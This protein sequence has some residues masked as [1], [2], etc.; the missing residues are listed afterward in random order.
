MKRLSIITILIFMIFINYVP[1]MGQSRLT[2]HINRLKVDISEDGAL[3]YRTS[4][5]VIQATWPYESRYFSATRARKNYQESWGVWLAARNFVGV[6]DSIPHYFHVAC[7]NRSL[8]SE[9]IV[10]LSLNK[11]VRYPY[12]NVRISDG[13]TIHHEGF[14]SDQVVSSLP[15]DE[16]ITSVWTTALGLTVQLKTYA[17]A[18][19]KNL[20]YIIYD[21]KFTNTGNTDN[22]ALTR[23]L[24]APLQDVW[25]G[26]C[27]STDIKPRYGGRDQDDFFEYYGA[28]Y[29][30]WVNGDKTADSARIFYCWDGPEGDGTYEPDQ[31]TAEPRNPGYYA[32]GILHVDRQASDDLESGS[33]DGPS[34]PK[35]VRAVGTSSNEGSVQYQKM[36]ISLKDT[37]GY[38]GE[39]NYLM[40]CGPYTMPIN[41][42]VRIV[43]VQI[44]SGISRF[45]AKDLGLQLLAGEITQEEYEEVVATARDSVFAAFHAAKNAF[46]NRFKLPDPPPSP[47]SLLIV[48]GI[49]NITLNWSS[50]AEKA[51]D[52]ITRVE[53]FAGY[54]VY[55]AA[56]FPDNEWELIFECGG[57]TG[58][59]LTTCY[60]DTNLIM[61]FDYYYAVTAFDDGTQNFLNPGVSLESSRLTSSAFFGASSSQKAEVT[62]N[63]IKSNLR[64][65]PNPYNIRSL[66]FGDPNDISNS[67]NNKIIFVGLPAQCTIRIYTVAGD[68]V[69]VINH[70]NG[71]GSEAWDLVSDSQQI[72][73]SGLYI[74]DVESDLGDELIKFVVIR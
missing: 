49:G 42:D 66:N 14:G 8:S 1:V 52:Q 53:D 25:L 4:S 73:V 19:G 5:S 55:R 54:R 64:V 17:Y 7:G 10:P 32:V 40:A 39:A 38:G 26:I 9:K 28:N 59:P 41:E 56:V 24:S 20:D 43:L 60:I 67:E 50:S 16:Q 57:E 46:E 30:D 70:N 48:S 63:G 65:V 62:Y 33:S 44:I 74:A 34:Q 45:Q 21:Y 3:L 2:H 13:Q 36:S 51:K 27:F 23:E 72:I 35:T 18:S 22:N 37:S 29:E 15:C 69:K 31:N 6:G 12:P 58:V 47:D 61:G 71:L 11:S 68:L